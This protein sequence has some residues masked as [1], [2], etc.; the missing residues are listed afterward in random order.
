[1]ANRC[2]WKTGDV[3]WKWKPYKARRLLSDPIYAKNDG[4]GPPSADQDLSTAEPRHGHAAEGANSMEMALPVPTRTFLPRS[5]DTAMLFAPSGCTH[6]PP[7]VPPF[8]LSQNLS[9]KAC[10]DIAG[11]DIMKLKVLRCRYATLIGLK[12]LIIGILF[13]R[14]KKSAKHSVN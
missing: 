6:P 8:L 2:S 10:K 11:C 9:P 3:C 4:N 7:P 13:Q 12:G 5:P 14:L 1:M